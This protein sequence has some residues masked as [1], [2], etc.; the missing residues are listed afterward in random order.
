MKLHVGDGYITMLG[1]S[2]DTLV[3][4]VAYGG[5]KGRSA[6]RRIDGGRHW[7]QYDTGER[8]LM[9]LSRSALAPGPAPGN[10]STK[11][12]DHG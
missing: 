11:G 7:F 8:I 6:S 9:I 2:L 4:R 3:R 5:R 1:A 12:D 10:A